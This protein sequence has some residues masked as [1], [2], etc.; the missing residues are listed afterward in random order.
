MAIAINGSGTVTGISVGGLPDG[1]V[2]AGTLASNSVETAKINAEAV[3]AGK[4]GNGGIIQ[5]L[6][7]T[8]TT[9]VTEN[10]HTAWADSGLTQAI[11][12][13]DASN[14]VLIMA[15][16][17]V[18]VSSSGASEIGAFAKLL[19]GS[20]A[21]GSANG[22]A[23]HFPLNAGGADDAQ[24]MIPIHFYDTPGAGTHTYKIQ[25]SPYSADNNLTMQGGGDMYSTLTLMEVVA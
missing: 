18:Y 7:M 3:G 21:L 16:L 19:R 5:V 8:T 14:K 11:T 13:T 4:I 25:G 10:D 15:N 1:I 24:S 2:D 20:T 23:A 9:D 6:H 22:I 17:F 12:M